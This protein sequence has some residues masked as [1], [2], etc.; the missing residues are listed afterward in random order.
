MSH[1][2]KCWGTTEQGVDVHLHTISNEGGFEA[3]VA[4]Y[5]ATLTKLKVPM[6][7]GR[8]LDVVL[9]F[10]QLTGY[11]QDKNYIGSTIGRTSSRISG[12]TFNLLG[13]QYFLDRNER[14]NH[15]HGGEKGFNSR[16]WTESTTT[17]S[18]NQTIKLS[19][20]SPDS[21]GG[22]PGNLKVYVTYT[23][24]E[25][26]LRI[27]YKAETDKPTPVNMTAHPYFNLDGDGKDAGNH[28]LKI[29]S[30]HILYFDEN[31]IPNGEFIPVAGTNADF[32]E[33]SPLNC[34]TTNTS[35]HPVKHD[36]F[37]P[38]NSGK[39][40]LSLGALARSHSSGLEMEIATTQCGIQLYSGDYLS[41]NTVGK[42][43]CIYGP[44]SGFCLEPQTHPDALNRPEFPSIILHP[45]NI[46]EHITEYRFRKFSKRD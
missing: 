41:K 22:Y 32:S 46:Y 33:F 44:R 7:E 38:L 13:K 42:Q 25:N 37:Y 40:K 39:D 26:G 19:Y 24:I 6:S 27:S 5:G 4:T 16:I 20:E 36:C 1:N 35:G 31:L 3:C 28:E 10:D 30:D 14:D 23:L 29:F 17:A 11:L 12:A 9:G 15:L 43:G 45:G 8:K 2:K 21:E 18:S 34:S